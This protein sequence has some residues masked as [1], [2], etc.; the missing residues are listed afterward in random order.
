MWPHN[1]VIFNPITTGGG[2]K[3][4]RALKL[5]KIAS[6]PLYLHT[7]KFVTFRFYPFDTFWKKKS[8]QSHM[9]F[10]WWR[11]DNKWQY[12]FHGQISVWGLKIEML[13]KSDLVKVFT[14]NFDRVLV[15][16]WVIHYKSKINIFLLFSLFFYCS[17][18]FSNNGTIVCPLIPN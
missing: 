13:I 16:I 12:I 5:F 10:L 6:K 18:L 14:W 7:S 11:H 17:P 15:L 4:T 2:V 8:A 9:S 3:V 1:S